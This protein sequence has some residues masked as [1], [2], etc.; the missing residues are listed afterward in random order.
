MD[1]LVQ[2]GHNVKIGE[3]SLV[4]AQV[5]I[6]GSASLGKNVVLGGQSAVKGHIHLDDGVMVAGKS[7]VH[8]NVPKGSVVSGYPAIPH[9]DWLKASIIFAKLPKLHGEMRDMRKKIVKM[10]EKI[11]P[12]EDQQ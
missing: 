11:F 2:V 7:G 8:S 5:G 1:I 3:N 6:A 4:V 10:Y 12:E 9:K